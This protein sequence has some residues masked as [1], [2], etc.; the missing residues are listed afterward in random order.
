MGELD[1][2]MT[3]RFIHEME[4]L[5]RLDHPNILKIYEIFEDQKRF[6]LVMELCAGGEL[7]DELTRINQFNELEAAQIMQQILEAVAYC[8]S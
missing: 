7:Y 2:Y 5:N 3:Q 6:Y 4:I 8:H 1:G